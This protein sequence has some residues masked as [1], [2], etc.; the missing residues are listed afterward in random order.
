VTRSDSRWPR[1]GGR[2]VAGG[3]AL[4]CCLQTTRS[5]SKKPFKHCRPSVRHSAQCCGTQFAGR[6]RFSE[7]KSVPRHCDLHDSE[8]QLEFL[9]MFLRCAEKTLFSQ[10]STRLAQGQTLHQPTTGSTR[11]GG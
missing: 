7:S 6:R 9:D 8:V 10:D 5:D 2:A 11:H 3:S 1:A 4:H